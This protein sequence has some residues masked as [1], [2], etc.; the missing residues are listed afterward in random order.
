MHGRGVFI[1]INGY[2]SGAL[3]MLER[4]GVKNTVLMDGEDIT[5]V[6]SELLTFPELLERKIHGAQTRGKC[7]I[8]PITGDSKFKS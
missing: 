5:L 6:L 8:H 3:S 7:Y 4:G 2:T 1:S